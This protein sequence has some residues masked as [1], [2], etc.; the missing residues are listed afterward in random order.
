MELT[1]YINGVEMKASERIRIEAGDYFEDGLLICGKCHTPKQCRVNILGNER[2]PYCLCKCEAERRDREAEKRLEAKFAEYKEQLRTDG[3]PDA[4]MRQWTFEN[5]DNGNP[6]L[7]GA[8]RHYV[9]NF[10]TFSE[11]GEGLLLWGASGTGKT[12]AACEVANAL[13]DRGYSVLVTGFTKIANILQGSMERQEYLD[14]LRSYRLLV[15]D[16]LGAERKSE[17]MS[18]IIFSVIDSRYRS[19]L[20]VIV[21]TNLGIEEIKKPGDPANTRIYDR[22]IE[23]CFPIEVGGVSRR[24]KSVRDNYSGF[25]ELLGL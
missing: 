19:G 9:D 17:Y 20:P 12:Y 22:I 16:D 13:I 21:T 6:T 5:D 3:L 11:Y 7:T 24:R 14:G 8:M 18:E 1:D 2:T 25:K 23:K 15:L 10:R 4:W